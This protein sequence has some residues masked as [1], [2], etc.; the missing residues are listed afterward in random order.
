MPGRFFIE[1]R[2][3]DSLVRFLGVLALGRVSMEL[4]IIFTIIFFDDGGDLCQ[5]LLTE[6][7]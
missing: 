1:M 3:S 5:G 6:I 7:R 4:Q 2:R